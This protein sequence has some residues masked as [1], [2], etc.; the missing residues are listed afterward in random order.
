MSLPTEVSV[1][2]RTFLELRIVS[3]HVA[4]SLCFVL[5]AQVNFNGTLI[6]LFTYDQLEQQS[7]KNLTNKVKDLQAILGADKLPP[8]TGHGADITID[9]I[10]TVQ[11]A[12]CMGKGVRLTPK[13]FGA[14]SAADSDGYF[15]RGEAIP[16]KAGQ[17][18]RGALVEQTNASTANAYD[19]ACQGAELAR[20]RNQGSNIFG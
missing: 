12:I 17:Q 7:R 6:P 19:E 18:M 4:V 5:R 9:W 8:L 15:G 14:P 16:Q 2:N 10:L 11:C 1:C 3:L 13:D 20:R